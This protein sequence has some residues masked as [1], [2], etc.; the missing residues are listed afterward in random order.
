MNFTLKSSI[1]NVLG[2]SEADSLEN[3]I[4]ALTNNR[5]E[6][7]RA[8]CVFP[9]QQVLCDLVSSKTVLELDEP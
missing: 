5:G 6:L 2:E 9:I 1:R 8:A 7:D 3:A 4:A